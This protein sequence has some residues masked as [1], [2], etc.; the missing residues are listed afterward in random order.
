MDIFLETYRLPRLSQEERD[1]LNRP[2][3]RSEIG[4]VVEKLPANQSTELDSFPGEFYQTY[5][6]LIYLSQTIPKNWR[7]GNTPINSFCKASIIFIQKSKTA[8]KWILQANISNDYRCKH[9][10]RNISK[11][12]PTIHKKDH[13]PWT[14]WI[15]SRVTRMIQHV[16]INQCHT[17]H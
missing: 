14:N 17:P 6:E 12:N 2:I 9:P 13:T 3:T 1:K 10:Q 7:E 4:S 8:P 5:K 16:Q 15:Y 11:L